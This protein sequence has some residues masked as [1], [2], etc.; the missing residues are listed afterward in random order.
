MRVVVTSPPADAVSLADAKAH[1]R[2]DHAD[3]DALI[4]GL[5]AAATQSIDGPNGWLGRA[6][7]VQTLEAFLPAFGV[8]SIGLPY[9]PAIDIVEVG[10][11][12]AADKAE[13]V[14]PSIYE[15]SGQLLRARWGLHWPTAAWRG[16]DAEVVRIRYR[17]GYQVIPA[18]IRAA[19]LLMTGDLYGQRETFLAGAAPAVA[20]MSTTVA[21]LLSPFRVFA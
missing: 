8:A 11:L 5:V 19:I 10:Y 20:P 3:E 15:L 4:A 6:I 18:P 16:C 21:T 17:A 13:V 12:D 9:P 7:G 1:L 14:D 2:V